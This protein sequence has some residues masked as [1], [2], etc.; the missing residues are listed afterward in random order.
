MK[1]L[2]AGWLRAAVERM[3]GMPDEVARGFKEVGITHAV[4]NPEISEFDTDIMSDS[5]SDTD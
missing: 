2:H 1:P 4:E 3:S 5:D